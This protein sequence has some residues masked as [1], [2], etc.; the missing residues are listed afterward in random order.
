MRQFVLD[1]ACKATARMESGEELTAISI[2]RQYLGLAEAH[3]RDSFMPP[4][5]EEVCR[6]W[7]A[8][9]D[10][11]EQGAPESV[12]GILDWAMKYASTGTTC[13][14][15]VGLGCGTPAAGDAAHRGVAAGTVRDRNPLRSTRREGHLLPTRTRGVLQ[16][17]FP[18]V[19]NIE[20]AMHNPPAIGRANLRGRVIQRLH[21]Q[22]GRY[23]CD[24]T[25]V[26]DLKEATMLDL[27]DPFEAAE[28]W[29]AA[30]KHEIKLFPPPLHPY[31]E[32]I[33]EIH[34]LY[35]GE[36]LKMPGNSSATWKSR[37]PPCSPCGCATC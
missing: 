20:H 5:A 25:G 1:P 23:A 31:E 18:G 35:C 17:Q 34:A 36:G 14:G 11:L 21:G 27:S 22:D 15:R 37:A 33:A 19:D 7:R 32:I 8:I 29:K 10:R 6:Q 4:W 16:H 9:L 28:H 12:A 13:V 30:P 24:W 26:W 3:A 2:Q